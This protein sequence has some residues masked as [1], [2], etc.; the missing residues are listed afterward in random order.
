MTVSDIPLKEDFNKYPSP[1][2]PTSDKFVQWSNVKK[3][4]KEAFQKDSRNSG[5]R[6]NQQY[7]QN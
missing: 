4:S 5:G 7:T 2:T 3:P 1:S 6:K